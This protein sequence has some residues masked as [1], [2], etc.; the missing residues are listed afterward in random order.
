MKIYVLIHSINRAYSPASFYETMEAFK[1]MEMAIEKIEE[2]K[3]CIATGKSSFFPK[4]SPTPEQYGIPDIPGVTYE[5]HDEG[6][7]EMF[8]HF[9][10]K[11][12]EMKM[13]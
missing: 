8:T 10:I 2:I 13:K 6:G 3:E 7:E 1:T 4:Q 5:W 12:I 9:Y 11:E